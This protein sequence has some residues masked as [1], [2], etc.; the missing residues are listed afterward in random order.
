MNYT[1]KRPLKVA[2]G[3]FRDQPMTNGHFSVYAQML[4]DNDIVIIGL[5]SMQKSAEP[6][7]PYTGKQKIEFIR[8]AFGHGSKDKLKIVPLYDIGATSEEQW[9]QYCMEQIDIKK[10]PTPTRYY[11]GSET[12]LHWFKGSKNLNGDDIELINLN[13]HETNMLSGTLVRQSLSMGTEEWKSHVPECLID[14][15]EE[16]Y[17]KELTLKYQQENF[18]KEK[19]L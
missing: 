14:M 3:A 9:V 2:F 6:N 19:E 17:P 13:R 8:T 11:A 12:D 4:R 1:K 15:I 18:N 16:W 5:G 10:L 7:D